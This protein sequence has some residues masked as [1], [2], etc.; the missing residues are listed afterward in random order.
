MIIWLA[1]YPKSGNTWLRAMLASY[2]YTNDGEFNFDVLDNIDQFPSFSHFQNF[3]DTFKK[4]ESTSKYWIEVQQKINEDKKL[5]FFKTHN[6][7]CKIDNNLFTD[8]KNTL[9]V[10]YIIR[11]PRNVITSLANHYDKNINEALEFMKDEKRCLLEKE[12]DRYIGFVSLFS[13]ISHQRSWIKNKRF[14]VLTIRYEDL[15][16]QTF[17][18]FEKV[19]KFIKSI[20][21]IENSFDRQKARKVVQSCDF[22]RMQK[23]EKDKGFPESVMKKEEDKKIKFFNLGP[24]NDF[25]H[26]L[27]KETIEEMNS[28]YKEQLKEF[29]YE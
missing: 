9:G 7:L 1:S 21:N 4:P 23:L 20:S 25:K 5:K 10:I 17:K 27:N 2:F 24:K 12:N 18:E 8:Q 29:N 15:S 6:A 26:I 28:L 14:P 16:S 19:F 3:K 11:D 22:Y 13:W